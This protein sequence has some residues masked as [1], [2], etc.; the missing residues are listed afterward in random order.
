MKTFILQ[1]L[2]ILACV[3]SAFAAFAQDTTFTYQGRVADTNGPL[4]GATA[5]EFRLYAT[6]TG[7][8]PLWQ[9][10]HPSI[11]VTNGL[12]SV[13][14]GASATADATIFNGDKRWLGISVN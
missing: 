9:E 6:A 14:L 12:F 3:G 7:G 8:T 2:I 5:M 13:T 11:P 1:K 10:T 4:N